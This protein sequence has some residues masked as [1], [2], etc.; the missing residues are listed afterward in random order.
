[1]DLIMEGRNLTKTFG[2]GD[3]LVTAVDAM[4]LALLDECTDR[5]DLC[6]RVRDVGML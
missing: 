4:S 1:M 6:V 5:V 2:E 3:S